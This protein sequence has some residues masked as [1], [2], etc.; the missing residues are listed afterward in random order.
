MNFSEFSL[1]YWRNCSRFRL[2]GS[3]FVSPSVAEEWGY[4][5]LDLFDFAVA[6]YGF[7]LAFGVTLPFL[8]RSRRPYVANLL[9]NVY[10]TVLMVQL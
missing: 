8:S 2:V 3:S 4:L 7:F 6:V 1:R 9:K 10:H 5:V